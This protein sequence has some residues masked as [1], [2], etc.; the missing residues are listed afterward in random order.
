[1]KIMDKF[2]RVLNK[3]SSDKTIASGEITCS[4]EYYV[5]EYDRIYLLSNEIFLLFNCWYNHDNHTHT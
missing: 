5:V 3:N 4:F 1:M 2:Q